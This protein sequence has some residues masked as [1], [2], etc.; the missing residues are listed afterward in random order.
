VPAWFVALVHPEKTAVNSRFNQR[1]TGSLLI[2]SHPDDEMAE[3]WDGI[4]TSSRSDRRS[5]RAFF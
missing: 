2:T 4:V 1:Q 3:I 5:D